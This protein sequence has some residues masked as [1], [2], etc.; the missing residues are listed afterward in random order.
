MFLLKIFLL[1][2]AW[3]WGVVLAGN[4]DELDLNYRATAE[5]PGHR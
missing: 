5:L 3:T 2:V 4:Q 1:L